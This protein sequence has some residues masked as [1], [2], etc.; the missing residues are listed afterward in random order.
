MP[1]FHLYQ[2]QQSISDSVG[3]LQLDKARGRKPRALRDSP[4]S[5]GGTEGQREM[6]LGAGQLSLLVLRANS[7]ALGGSFLGLL[8]GLSLAPSPLLQRGGRWAG[9]QPLLPADGSRLAH[10]YILMTRQHLKGG[11]VTFKKKRGCHLP[12][13]LGGSGSIVPGLCGSEARCVCVLPTAPE[14][15]RNSKQTFGN[16]EEGDAAR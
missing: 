4:L 7:I 3:V 11:N 14:E 12:L 1:T 6:L 13:R 16:Q 5:R 10:F 15:C 9:R 2:T 8:L